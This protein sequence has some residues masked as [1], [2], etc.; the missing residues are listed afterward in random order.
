[1]DEALLR[2]VAD[3][4]VFTLE[5]HVHTGGFGAAVCSYCAENK[6]PAPAKIFALPDAFITHGNRAKLLDD[7]GLTAEQIVADII[8][9]LQHK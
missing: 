3:K 1:M 7:C 2:S 9:I 8:N 4:P 5:E 6:L